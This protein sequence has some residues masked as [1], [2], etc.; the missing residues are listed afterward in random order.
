M[1]HSHD[2]WPFQTLCFSSARFNIRWKMILDTSAEWIIDHRSVGRTIWPGA[3]LPFA[4]GLHPYKYRYASF[5][6]GAKCRLCFVARA[7]VTGRQMPKVR[8]CFQNFPNFHFSR[9][10]SLTAVFDAAGCRRL[11]RLPDT[12][13]NLNIRP[14][15]RF[16]RTAKS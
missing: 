4:H 12:V 16:K 13:W 6:W 7:I 9:S 1:Y 5:Q 3:A 11:P 14:S 2:F 10:S 15:V 8:L